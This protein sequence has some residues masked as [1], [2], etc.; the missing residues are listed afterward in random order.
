MPI[1]KMRR[2]RCGGGESEVNDPKD[3]PESDEERED[4]EERERV[5]QEF[6]EFEG[7][8]EFFDEQNNWGGAFFGM[9]DDEIPCAGDEY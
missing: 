6:S 4:R 9:C 1:R 8:R 5:N 7:E 3:R 2:E